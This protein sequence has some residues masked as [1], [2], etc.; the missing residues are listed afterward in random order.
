MAGDIQV[1]DAGLRVTLSPLWG[2][3]VVE[4]KKPALQAL[5]LVCINHK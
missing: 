5:H 3:V 2:M 4:C 1:D